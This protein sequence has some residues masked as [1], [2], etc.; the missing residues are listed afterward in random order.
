MRKITG[1]FPSKTKKLKFEFFFG[2]NVIQQKNGMP[3]AYSQRIPNVYPAPILLPWI[4]QRCHFHGKQIYTL[5]KHMAGWHVLSSNRKNNR[6]DSSVQRNTAHLGMQRNVPF[7]LFPGLDDVYPALLHN[8]E[9]VYSI[10][11]CD[12]NLN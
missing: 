5:T 3:C 2:L 12:K 9:S 6:R 1:E 4:T 11:I 10:P 7:C 8:R